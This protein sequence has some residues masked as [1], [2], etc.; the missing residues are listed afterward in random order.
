MRAVKCYAI[1]S[2]VLLLAVGLVWG[3]QGRNRGDRPDRADRAGRMGQHGGM[4]GGMMMGGVQR[5]QRVLDG[6][7]L[8]DQQR[9]T[10]EAFRVEYTEKIQPLTEEMREKGKAM[11]DRRQNDPDDAEGFKQMREEMIALR[12][13]MTRTT[14]EFTEKVKG[15]LT[16]QQKTKLDEALA[17]RGRGN[18]IDR[19]L[20]ALMP[21]DPRALG[22]LNPTEEQRQK[23]QAL[24][25]ELRAAVEKLRADYGEKFKE[26]LT[27]EQKQKLEELKANPPRRNREAMR[28]RFRNHGQ[29]RQG[30]G[31]NPQDAN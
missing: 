1:T 31:R 27:D 26:L 18:R 12:Q 28:E 10:I 15:E 22:E 2:L 30:G 8:T 21:V 4:R 9:Q 24:V 5:I 13:E 19:I 3:Q 23:F 16:D 17:A 7:E 6:L 29:R 14:Q 20:G 11:R 25:E